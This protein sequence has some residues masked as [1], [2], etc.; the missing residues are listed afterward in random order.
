MP[1]KRGSQRIAISVGDRVYTEWSDW[2][3]DDEAYRRAGG[4]RAY[5]A[6]RQSMALYRR[7][8]LMEI[9]ARNQLNLWSRNGAQKALARALGVSPSTVSRDIKAILAEYRPGKP[10]PLCRCEVRHILRGDSPW[11]DITGE[12]G[13]E[14]PCRT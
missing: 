5:N 1:N 14:Q 7:M 3:S 11:A 9:A 2:T 12:G 8:R 4:R 6:W 13:E 10:C